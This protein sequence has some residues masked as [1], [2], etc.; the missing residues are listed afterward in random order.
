MAIIKCPECGR[1]ISDKAPACPNCGVPIAGKIVRCP[2][3][4]EIYFK[5]QEMCPN[6]HH[7]TPRGETLVKGQVGNNSFDNNRDLQPQSGTNT[8]TFEKQ[9]D[10]ARKPQPPTPPKT[11]N[12]Y[13]RTEARDAQ[14]VVPPTSS[15]HRQKPEAPKK[16]YS[17]LIIGLILQLPVA[18]GD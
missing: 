12:S 14:R 1:Q 2:Q 9:Q 15:D 10:E 8:Q 7:L 6:C 17:A 18:E 4:G 5:D 3:C 13:Q 11:S 16:S